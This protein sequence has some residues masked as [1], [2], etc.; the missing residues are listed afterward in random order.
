MNKFFIALCLIGVGTARADC[1]DL[2][3]RYSCRTEEGRVYE[4]ELKMKLRGWGKK[5]ISIVSDGVDYGDILLDN[6]I[7]TSTETLDGLTYVHDVKAGC[8]P[9]VDAIHILRST[10]TQETQTSTRMVFTLYP[11][12]YGVINAI[13]RF[14]ADGNRIGSK[15]SCVKL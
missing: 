15:D 8:I 5:V 9:V 10:T 14:D 13:V 4:Q 12:D 7:H 2:S 3:G 6:Q 11:Q 1:P